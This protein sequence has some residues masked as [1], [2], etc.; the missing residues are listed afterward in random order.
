[1]TM[2]FFTLILLLSVTVKT[3]HSQSLIHLNPKDT[4]FFIGA[5]CQIKSNQPQAVTIE[6]IMKD[7]TFSLNKSEHVL[8]GGA[9]PKNIWLKFTVDNQK[10]NRIFLELMFPLVDRATLYTVENN[11]VIE[12]QESG[13]NQ[14]FEVRTLHTNTLT[15]NLKKSESAIITYYL[16]VNV[17]WVC[18]IKPRIGTYNSII[19]AHHYSDLMHGIF[20][21]VIMVLILYNFF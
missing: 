11:Q 17:K 9:K 12:V 13:Q 10:N 16:N 6:E 4:L 3:A 20:F 7:S 5:Q 14:P 19:R 2:R 8:L 18:N 21:G 1:M 15:F